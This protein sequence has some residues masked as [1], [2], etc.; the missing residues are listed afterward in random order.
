MIYGGKI[1]A[2]ES[3]PE[4]FSTGAICRLHIH[5]CL[6][7][8]LDPVVHR[9][10]YSCCAVQGDE[11]KTLSDGKDPLSPEYGVCIAADGAVS[12]NVSALSGLSEMEFGP[13]Q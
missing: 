3:N 4:C 1:I 13:L 5:T 11:L 2:F 10:A 9:Q 12:G 6:S 7:R 8:C